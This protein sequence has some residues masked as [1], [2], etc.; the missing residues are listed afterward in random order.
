MNITNEQYAQ[1]Q[2]QLQQQAQLASQAAAATHRL[3]ASQTVAEQ[4][5]NL[6]SMH[7]NN[8]F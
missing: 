1:L 6:I 8:H 3:P 4:Q 7:R 5:S 2:A